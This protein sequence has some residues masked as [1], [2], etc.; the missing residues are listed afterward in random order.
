MSSSRTIQI[1]K[2]KIGGG[3]PVAVQSMTNTDTRDAAATLA[4]ITRLHE[5]GCEIIRVAVPDEAAAAALREICRL[6]PL[7]VIA[8][9]HFDH[10]LALSALKNGVH[11]LRINPGNIG[12]QSAVR[13]VAEAAAERS[14]PIRVG[15]NSGSV[16]KDLLRRFGGPTP[17]AMVESALAHVRLLEEQNFQDIKI[18]IKSSSVTDTVAAYRLLAGRC[19]YPLHIGVTEAGT[20]LRGA[21]KSAV[22]LGILL[23]EG[24]GDTL[25]VSLTHDPV[26]E[27][28]VA[29][30]ILRALGLR[31]RGPEIISC[32]TCGRTEIDLIGLADAVEEK[33][34]GVEEVFTLAVMGC[35]VNGP[36]EAREADIGIAGGRGKAVIFRKGIMLRSLSGGREDFLAALLQEVDVFLAERRGAK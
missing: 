36:G 21:V 29:W 35:V 17:E 14:V 27:V 20:L 30:E 34:R 8:D 26:R 4:Q 25:R 10:R 9:I 15:V 3:N 18:S 16:E 7:P 31:A 11:G 5:A 13:A 6:S 1:G 28:E 2:V 24:I 12:G 33:L 32:P 23:A 22:G 19:A